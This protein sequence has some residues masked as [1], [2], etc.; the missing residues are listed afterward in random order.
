MD[1]LPA[2]DAVAACLAAGLGE[3][4]RCVEA[5]GQPR[6]GRAVWAAESDGRGP[7]VV[8]ARRGELADAGF[9]TVERDFAAYQSH[10]LFD[11]WD[12]VWRDA[13]TA[14]LQA[15]RLCVRLR[16][17]LRPVWGHRLEARDFA[18]NDLNLTNV[19]VEGGTITGVVDWDTGGLNSRAVDLT[20][21]AFDCVLLEDGATADAL[22][23]RI[24]E[25]VGEDGLRCVVAYRLV[26]HVASRARRGEL[27][28]V[29][30]SAAAGGRFLDALGAR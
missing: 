8:K 18:H 17:W 16:R 15:R 29:S 24:V 11:G 4:V 19:L 12:H 3:P 5:L 1:A 2:W 23:K 22:A 26:S 7:L 10:V 21:L 30:E 25:L 6:P 27:G 20:A 28:G 13:E 9:D 14:S